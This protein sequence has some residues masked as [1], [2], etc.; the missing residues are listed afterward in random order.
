MKKSP[1]LLALE[2]K[3]EALGLAFCSE[4]QSSIPEDDAAAILDFFE[5]NEYGEALEL[6]GYVLRHQSVSLGKEAHAKLKNMEQ[7]MKEV[8]EVFEGGRAY[9]QEY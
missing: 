6:I 7:L 5:H 4:I 3:I 2:E 8:S 9:S 1:E